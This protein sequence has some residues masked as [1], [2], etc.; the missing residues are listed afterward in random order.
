MTAVRTGIYC[1]TDMLTIH[2]EIVGNEENFRC[3][4]LLIRHVSP[5][6]YESLAKT[7]PVEVKDWLNN[8]SVSYWSV[9]EEILMH[10]EII[11]LP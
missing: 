5:L 8:V 9:L 7:Y 11:S 1:L 4:T 6:Q 3:K 2:R 10:G